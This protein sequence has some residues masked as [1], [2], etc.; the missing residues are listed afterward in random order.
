MSTL[1]TSEGLGR[2]MR[3]TTRHNTATHGITDL[4]HAP[5]RQ[6]IPLDVLKPLFDA[7]ND[8]IERAKRAYYGKT[9]LDRRIAR[10]EA[11]QRW[12]AK[13]KGQQQ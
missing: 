2:T 8:G 11:N 5:S 4:D 10:S 13:K 9:Y 3:R 12:R 1:N 7:W 6:A